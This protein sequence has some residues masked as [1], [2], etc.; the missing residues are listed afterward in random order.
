MKYLFLLFISFELFAADYPGNCF[1]SRRDKLLK[2][3]NESTLYV[4]PSSDFYYDLNP[5]TGNYS[6]NPNLYYLT[7]IKEPEIILLMSKSG[8]WVGNYA[9]PEVIFINEKIGNPNSWENRTIGKEEVK[10]ISR[11]NLILPMRIFKEIF[12][13]NLFGRDSVILDIPFNQFD[14]FSSNDFCGVSDYFSDLQQFNDLTLSH[15]PAIAKLRSIKD[16][17]EIE[18]IKSAVQISINAHS[19]VIKS[20]KPGQTEKEIATKFRCS[21][22]SQ[23][24]DGAAYQPIVASGN[25]AIFYHYAKN[26]DTCQTGDLLLMDCGSQYENYASDIARTVPVSG[27]FS[28]EQ[29][30]LYELVLN[31]QVSAINECK[32][33]SSFLEPHN[34]AKETIAKG[35]IKLGIIQSNSDADTYFGHGTSHHVG[36]EVHDTMGYGT[37]EPGMVITV[38]PGVYIPEGSDCDEKWWGTGIRIEDMILITET[39]CEILSGSL[40][41][42]ITDI[43]NLMK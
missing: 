33:G 37:L 35:L 20:L 23:G 32:P 12:R 14:K 7:G 28:K 15:N 25:N 39:G 40:P 43:E 27:K 29:I 11:I 31:A 1:S 9:F 22:L 30:D 13:E 21:F 19:D 4:C 10:K 36:L 2:H 18:K 24:A 34:I 16:S 6:Q 42:T 26:S 3:F 17:I 38:E 41:K 5:F 8:I